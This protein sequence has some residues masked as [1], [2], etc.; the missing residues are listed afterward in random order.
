MDNIRCMVVLLMF[1][2]TNQIQSILPHLPHDDATIGVFLK[3]CFEYKSPY[4]SKNV[5]SNMMII[6]L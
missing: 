3:W 4:M 2:Q 5:P 1:L 6:I